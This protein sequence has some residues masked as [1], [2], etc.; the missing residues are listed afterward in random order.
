M[1]K[2]KI[3]SLILCALTAAAL[4]SCS[5]QGAE[6]SSSP[7][8]TTTQAAQSATEAQTE[9]ET[10]STVSQME[11][12]DDC[13]IYEATYKIPGEEIYMGR[14]YF[15]QIENGYTSVFGYDTTKYIAVTANKS[16]D[17]SIESLESAHESALEKYIQNAQY[18]GSV[19][20]L[21]IETDSTE[22]IN[23]LDVYK[24][25]G[26]F[27]C[28]RDQPYE[29]YAIGYSFIMDDTPCNI[30]GYVSREEKTDSDLEAEIKQNVEAMIYTVRSEE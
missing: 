20:S 27:D 15:H 28:G 25:E 16:D 19:N 9:S 14:P 10:E 24:F 2:K 13:T 7:E 8:A 6:P 22:N 12:S 5:G 1:S 4:A 21:N 26:T 11:V 23:G 17:A 18:E 29:A 30:I 3:M